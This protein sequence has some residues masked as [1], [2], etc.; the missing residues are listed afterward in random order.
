MSETNWKGDY[1]YEN[2]RELNKNEPQ[3]LFEQS[4]GKET[5]GMSFIA[6][7]SAGPVPVAANHCYLV[8]SILC[9]VTGYTLDRYTLH[10]LS[11]LTIYTHSARV[12]IP[13]HVSA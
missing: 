2:S 10:T 8:G 1:G 12:D 5:L 9:A 6:G 7:S 4:R 3:S 13:L 11:I